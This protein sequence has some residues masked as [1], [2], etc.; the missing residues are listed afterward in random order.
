M[1]LSNVIIRSALLTWFIIGKRNQRTSEA[2]C[3]IYES[4]KRSLGSKLELPGREFIAFPSF[5]SLSFDV[6]NSQ[7]IIIASAI[8]SHSFRFSFIACCRRTFDRWLWNVQF[9]RGSEIKL[10]IWLNVWTSD[11][12]ISAGETPQIHYFIHRM[13]LLQEHRASQILYIFFVMAS[14]K[15]KDSEHPSLIHLKYLQF[16]WGCWRIFFPPFQLL[17]SFNGAPRYIS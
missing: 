17:W 15:S 10:N 4:A 16:C 13:R 5:F 7:I 14:G 8:S 3:V 9:W 1:E 2:F 11:G 12:N 6:M